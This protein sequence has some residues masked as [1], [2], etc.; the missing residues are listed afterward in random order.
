[1]QKKKILGF[2]A[3]SFICL[4]GIQP[5]WAIEEPGALEIVA[6]IAP[7]A[8]DGIVP[9]VSVAKRSAR[10]LAPKPG[11]LFS[12]DSHGLRLGLSHP[13]LEKSTQFRGSN[14]RT[15]KSTDGTEFI[16][17]LK[18]DGSVQTLAIL[19]SPDA[20]KQLEF[21][22]ELPTNAKAD[23]LESGEVVITDPQG[24]F[25]AG[26]SAP[27]AKDSNGEAVHTFFEL[28][29][30]KVIQHVLH[31][32]QNYVYPIVA[33]PWFGID[34]YN[35]PTVTFHT[36]GYRI[37]VSPTIWG[38]TNTAFSK[39]FAHRDEVKTKLGTN[40]WRW[41]N[42]IQEQFYCHIAGVP[43]SLPEYNMESWQP[44]VNWATSLTAYLC[45]PDKGTWY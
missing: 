33:D 4:Q 21:E 10:S 40:A 11:T 24:K 29:S 17:L 22:L 2:I 20:Q 6:R 36:K 39:W 16:P 15:L 12:S 3:G 38:G 8:F 42:T 27:W 30:G 34:L 35:K 13:D 25:L 7:Q 9:D 43:A 44:L 32:S 41:T 5:S 26:I 14:Y 28:K 31:N 45:N 1:L 19:R 37:N 18:I 23:L